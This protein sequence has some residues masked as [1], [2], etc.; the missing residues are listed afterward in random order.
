MNISKK[1]LTILKSDLVLIIAATLALLS[2]LFV[3]PSINYINYIDFRVL[4]LLFCLMAVVAGFNKTGVFLH[5]SRKLLN[6]VSHLRAL[7]FVL[8]LLCFFSSMWITNDVALITFVPFTLMLL[9]LTGQTSSMIYIIVME[10]IAA[11]LGSMLT[12]VGNPQ[13]LYLYSYYNISFGEFII[14]VLPFT[15][16]SLLVLGLSVLAIKKEPLSFELPATDD[17]SSQ[18]R[19]IAIYTFLFVVCIMSVLHFIDY[20]VALVIVLLCN[21]AY[22]RKVLRKVDYGLL[23]TFVCFFLFIGNLGS[24]EVIKNFISTILIGRELIVSTLL[25]Q[26]ISNVPAAVLLSTF[27]SD[28]KSLLIG[29]NLGG[30]GTLIASLASLIS[31]KFYCKT[32]NAQPIKYLITFTGINFLFLILLLSVTLIL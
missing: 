2:M 30:L 6:Q 15:V 32:Q 25:S 26:V 18:S 7:A 29:T 20:P 17:L 1:L 24:L 10:T 13:N 31:F 23:L 9:G 28:Y 11:N 22:D 12:P 3:A 14:T 19:G 5:L 4:S 21:C 27:T 16:I 8:F